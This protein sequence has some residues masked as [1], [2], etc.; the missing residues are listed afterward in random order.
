M[1]RTLADRNRSPPDPRRSTEAQDVALIGR[2]ARGELAAFEAF[3]RGYHARLGRFLGLMTSRHPVVEEA[4]NDTMLVIWKRAATFNGKSKVSTW[5]FAIAYRT[6]LQALRSQDEPVEDPDADRL[7]AQVIGPE[8]QRSQSELRAA[9]A[10]ALDGLSHEQRSVLVLT[11]FHDLPYAE[12]ALILDCP[13]DTV[14]T[15]AFHGRRRLRALL[16]GEPEDWL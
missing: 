10:R 3:Y 15:R 16:A 2:I 13:V 11:Y 12:I 9:L 6:A 8:Q 1:L 5:V 4:L 7:A 14:K